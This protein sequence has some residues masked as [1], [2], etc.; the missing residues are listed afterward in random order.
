M[1]HGIREALMVPAHEVED[2]FSFAKRQA[3][4]AARASDALAAAVKA[5][6]EARATLE[7]LPEWKRMDEMRRELADAKKAALE[8]DPAVLDAKAALKKARREVRGCRESDDLKQRRQ[9]AKTAEGAVRLANRA[10]VS[11]L[12]G[13]TDSLPASAGEVV[14]D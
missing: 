3:E 2:L 12:T 8:E 9:E 11:R 6:R 14:G 4:E 13:R 7:A 10:L 1:A 5:Q